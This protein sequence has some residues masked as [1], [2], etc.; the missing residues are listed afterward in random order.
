MEL[1]FLVQ[2]GV[3]FTSCDL[4]KFFLGKRYKVGSLEAVSGGPVYLV[5]TLSDSRDKFEAY[6]KVSKDFEKTPFTH[7]LRGCY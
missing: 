2:L 4:E 1:S 3:G 6:A 5:H 7:K